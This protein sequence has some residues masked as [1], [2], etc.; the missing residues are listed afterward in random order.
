M[1]LSVLYYIR[2]CQFSV[3]LET[4]CDIQFLKQV[5]LSDKTIK[6]LFISVR[7]PLLLD[8]LEQPTLTALIIAKF[9]RQWLITYLSKCIFYPFLDKLGCV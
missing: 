1:C 9:D 7:Y 5:I 2:V 3:C 8:L 4:N 6:T